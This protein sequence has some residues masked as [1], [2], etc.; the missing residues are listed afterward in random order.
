MSFRDVVSENFLTLQSAEVPGSVGNGILFC[1][2]YV[3]LGLRRIKGY[4]RVFGTYNLN[5]DY[6]KGEL[7]SILLNTDLC[8]L[9]K[10]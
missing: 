4:K 1:L 8:R 6:F 7:L 3:F 5:E 10:E 9:W 2:N